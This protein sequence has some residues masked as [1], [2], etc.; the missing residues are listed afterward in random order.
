MCKLRRIAASGPRLRRNSQGTVASGAR[1][2]CNLWDSLAP[3]ALMLCLCSL[4]CPGTWIRGRECIDRTPTFNPLS[5]L[6]LRSNLDPQSNLDL[7]RTSIDSGS[8]TDPRALIFDHPP[9]S[10]F[11]LT[12]MIDPPP[13]CP[14][15]PS[16]SYFSSFLRLLLAPPPLRPPPSSLVHHLP[17]FAFPSSSSSCSASSSLSSS[18]SS[19]FQLRRQVFIKW[20]I[21]FR[22][23]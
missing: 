10:I 5:I 21:R 14:R 20:L 23:G 13:P 11:D 7:C 16:S 1:L 2:W 22:G 12:S 9:S 15:H 8:F 17:A 19:L 3:K 4:F 6:C 18:A